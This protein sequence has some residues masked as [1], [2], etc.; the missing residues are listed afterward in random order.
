MV[1]AAAEIDAKMVVAAPEGIDEAMVFD[2]ERRARKAADAAGT[3]RPEIP[4]HP[5]PR[6]Q[7]GQVPGNGRAAILPRRHNHV[8]LKTECAMPEL[9]DAIE[10][11]F[12]TL[13]AWWNLYGLP[14]L[15]VVVASTV[16]DT[17]PRSPGTSA[18]AR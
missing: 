9:E 10:W 14:V 1:V 17:C 3:T 7:P 13:A 6:W 4:R 2:P 18:S 12:V 5:G 16:D 8:N 15:L 11:D